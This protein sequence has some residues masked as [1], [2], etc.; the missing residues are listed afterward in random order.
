MNIKLKDNLRAYLHANYRCNDLIRIIMQLSEE[1]HIHDIH[2]RIERVSEDYRRMLD[3]MRKGYQDPERGILYHKLFVKATNI[4]LDLY[5]RLDM[6][7]R[8]SFL[9]AQSRTANND[10]SHEAIR[11]VMEDMVTG[12]AMLSLESEELKQ[13][14]QAE[15]F[16]THQKKMSRIFDHILVSDGWTEA[17]SQF[18]TELIL[19]PTIE[20]NDAQTL[21]SAISLSGSQYFDF[22]K[23]KSLADIYLKTTDKHVRQRALVGWVFSLDDGFPAYEQE[24]KALCETVCKS[25]SNIQDLF[26]LQKQFYYCNNTQIDSNRIQN[27]I[28]GDLM[29]NPNLKF[30][31]FGIEEKEDSL[32]DI[33][34]PDASEKAMEEVEDAMRKLTDMQKQGMDIYFGGFSHM[35]RYAFFYDLSNWFVPFYIDHPD[36]KR[37]NTKLQNI[38][39]MKNL[40]EKGPF[41]DS[42]KYSFA[43]ALS[44][45]IDMIPD[46]VKEMLNNPD[47]TF[48]GVAV[49][50]TESP[51][52]IRRM[53][54]QDFYR[55]FNL[56]TD[57]RDFRNSLYS[58]NGETREFMCSR[59]F[60]ATELPKYS[61]EMISFLRKNFR[62]KESVLYDFAHAYPNKQE[63]GYFIAMGLLASNNSWGNSSS[64][65]R[66]ALELEPENEQAI[67]GLARTELR[68]GNAEESAALYAKL[69]LLH[70]E[71]K[72]YQINYSLALVKTGNYDL[73]L[74][75]L[76]RLNLE[77]PDDENVSRALGWGLLCK[78]NA[79]QAY[80]IYKGLIEKGNTII[81]DYLNMG[82]AAWGQHNIKEAAG[83]FKKYSDDP[84]S[85]M[86]NESL[87]TQA[88]DEDEQILSTYNIDKTERFLMIE[89][90]TQA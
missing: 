83:L 19:S 25:E 44:S 71:R 62:P 48:G 24:L 38:S 73:A 26:E 89:I 30:T 39:F 47:A 22:Q 79:Q 80:A 61:L 76:Y 11:S 28:M 84:R 85:G 87:L 78:G 10:F 8:P 20:S 56:Y 21:A 32:N 23:N 43:L 54:L 67:K 88:F 49:D 74:N 2:H 7:A 82:Y 59:L 90:A 53:Y 27:E 6:Q 46:N 36:L 75:T 81:D 33:L 72:S 69:M 9:R 77:N 17:D 41:C 60:Q 42:D 5:K 18:Y 37:A 16:D 66:N 13:Q 58:P 86:D 51:A 29:R 31:R 4:G 1:E 40:L 12:I 45:T 65:F 55:F 63:A 68:D 15:I 64:Y 52:Y 35:K 57:N 3:F 14:K 34:H 50:N 70:P